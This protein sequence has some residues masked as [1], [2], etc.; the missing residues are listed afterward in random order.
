MKSHKATELF[1][2]LEHKMTKTTAR[3]GR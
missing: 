3:N 1:Q 2:L